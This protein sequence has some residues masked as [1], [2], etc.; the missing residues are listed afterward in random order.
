M[1][2]VDEL[3][4]LSEVYSDLDRLQPDERDR[5]LEKHED[6]NR[7]LSWGRNPRRK[8]TKVRNP[9]YDVPLYRGVVGK[10]KFRVFYVIS[11][12]CMYCVGISPRR[13]AYESPLERFARRGHDALSDDG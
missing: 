12:E 5:I 10:S 2:D 4:V 7:Q 8:L 6:W 1:E 3:A 9:P 13:N 11:D